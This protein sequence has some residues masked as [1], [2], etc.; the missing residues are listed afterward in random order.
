MI[1]YNKQ[2]EDGYLTAI[3]TGAGGEEITKEE[4]DEILSVI[5]SCPADEAGYMYRLRADLT[6]ELTQAPMI[7]EDDAEATEEDYIAALEELGV[8][9]NEED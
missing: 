3:G 6:W 4:Y 1:R 7:E 5:R 2:I 8:T 9:V